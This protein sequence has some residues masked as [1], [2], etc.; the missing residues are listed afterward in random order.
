VAEPIHCH[1]VAFLL[2]IHYFTL[3]TWPLT[4][5]A[6]QCMS[7]TWWNCSKFERNR[8]ICRGVI[9]PS[10]FDLMTLNIVLC[11]ALSSGIIFTKFDLRQL[12][13]AWIIAFL[14]WYVMSHYDLDLWPFDLESWW[15]I[16]RHVIKVLRNL[17]KIKQFPIELLIILQIF[18]HNMSRCDLHLWPLD[19]DLL[20]H[21]GCHVFKL[22]QNLSEIE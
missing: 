10:T 14:C 22:L 12:I 19:L 3:W 11:I 16:K 9:A 13:C 17:S 8:P 6:V 4:T 15:Y 5:F 21:F 7:V 18:A 2:L 1:I 20:L